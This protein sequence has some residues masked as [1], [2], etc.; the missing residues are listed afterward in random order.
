MGSASGVSCSSVTDYVT[1]RKS[2]ELNTMQF[3]IKVDNQQVSFIKEKKNLFTN[4]EIT[5]VSYV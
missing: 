3:H 5:D 4:L 2:P 1:L